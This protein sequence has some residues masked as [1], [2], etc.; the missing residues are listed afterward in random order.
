MQQCPLF[1]NFPKVLRFFNNF[2]SFID[3]DATVE[4]QYVRFSNLKPIIYL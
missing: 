4:L 2:M 3:T 1:S